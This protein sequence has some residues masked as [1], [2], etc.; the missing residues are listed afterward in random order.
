MPRRKSDNFN[1]SVITSVQRKVEVQ[2][3]ST[4]GRVC[5]GVLPTR[6]A[7]ITP[8]SWLALLSRMCC[9]P[10]LNTKLML[11]SHTAAVIGIFLFFLKIRKQL[12]AKKEHM[13]V[14]PRASAGPDMYNYSH[15]H[16]NEW[17]LSHTNRCTYT[18][19]CYL[20]VRSLPASPYTN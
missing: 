6:V 17:T 20:W 3:G 12:H 11:L 19:K 1:T 7:G 5:P 10:Q 15:M 8:D 4:S 18:Q 16:A 13:W 2:C 9:G 14:L